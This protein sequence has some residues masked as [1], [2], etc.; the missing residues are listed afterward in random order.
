MTGSR[1]AGTT[2]LRCV[3]VPAEETQ[4]RGIADP[5]VQW[6]RFGDQLL[7]WTSSARALGRGAQQVPRLLLVTQMGRA[8]QDEHPDVVPVLDHGRHLV[9]DADLP[10]GAVRDHPS[11]W[12]AE[13][14]LP[15][16][17]VVDVPARMAPG[18]AV[19]RGLVD[20]LSQASFAADLEWLATRGTRH[21]LSAGFTEAA[22][23]AADRLTSLGY[24]VERHVIP[25]GSGASEN[26]A[27]ERAGTG[28]APRDL[29]VVTA[30]L[31]SV[32]LAGG[33]TAAAPGADDNG[34]GSAGLLEL[35]RVLAAHSWRHDVRLVLFGGEEQGLHGSRHYVAAMSAA[36]RTRVR[37]VLNMDMIGP[38]TPP[39]PRCCSRG[40]RSRPAS[41]T[42]S[43]QRPAAVTDLRV[44]TSL[45]P[46]ASD[47]VPFIEAGLPAVLT[48][49][50]GDSA[51]GNIHSDRDRL[52]HIDHAFALQILR[53]NLA[54]L[55]G[56]LEAADAPRPPAG[57]VVSRAP[58]RLDIFVVGADSALQ[59]KSWDGTAWIPGT[60]TFE[61]LGGVLL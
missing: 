11:C 20:E 57:S 45:S 4:S 31:D 21:S 51:N 1:S 59:H 12:R 46:F 61:N 18:R 48:I 34:S 3:V 7:L 39:P 38:A 13:P 44:E 2:T 50:G 16:S 35:G 47:H 28:A 27:A 29:V 53:M 42:P 58:G 43:P 8:F 56:W 24:A 17:V 41:S 40:T 22:S 54:A 25:V 49:E 55:K 60:D 36:D 52:E 30:H 10:V 26:V 19:A 14:L 5:A 23:W 15:G 9:V 32:N 33:A 37:A 6:A